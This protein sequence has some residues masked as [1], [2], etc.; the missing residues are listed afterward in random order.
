MSV[1]KA[2]QEF[3]KLLDYEY[4]FI[5]VRNRN[6]KPLKLTLTF[7]KSDFFH[8]CGFQYLNDLRHLNTNT[9]VVFDEI[10]NGNSQYS[11]IMFESSTYYAKI[12]DRVQLLEKLETLLDN[13]DKV[14]RSH[15]IF[16][17]NRNA[18]NNSRIEASLIIKGESDNLRNYFLLDKNSNKQYYGRSCFARTPGQKDYAD[19]HTA[20]TILYKGKINLLTNEREDLFLAP[21]YKAEFEAQRSAGNTIQ[22]QFDKPVSDNTLAVTVSDVFK[23]VFTSLKEQFRTLVQNIADKVRETVVKVFSKSQSSDEVSVPETESKNSDEEDK[24]LVFEME[25]TAV[26]YHEDYSE[27]I[28]IHEILPDIEFLLERVSERQTVNNRNGITSEQS[29]PKHIKQQIEYDDC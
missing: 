12:E 27:I 8:L 26:R 15:R 25:N 23:E 2:A 10:I 24:I 7:S 1:L 18:N 14:N 20:Y 4:E 11:D 3:Q 6:S 22:I 29:T 17:F 28:S 13:R 21:S 19:G 9:G 16:K 5:V